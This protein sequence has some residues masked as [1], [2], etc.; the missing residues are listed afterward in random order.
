MLGLG[1]AYPM[2]GF[3]RRQLVEYVEYHRDPRNC[4]MHVLGITTLFLGA[5]MPLTQ[6]PVELL[7]LRVN[8]AMILASPVLL[9]WLVLDAALGMGLVFAAAVLLTAASFIAAHVSPHAMW[10]IFAVL[11]VVG[12]AAQAIGHSVFEQ[13]K[14][15][16]LDHPVHFLLGPPFVMAKLFNLFGFRRDLAAIIEAPPP[17]LQAAIPVE[18]R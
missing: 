11:L 3:F 7:G 12:F 16:L 14:P 9:Y 6:V 10:A 1:H 2:N 4:G 8:L 17:P 18:Q 13:R 15:S 5:V